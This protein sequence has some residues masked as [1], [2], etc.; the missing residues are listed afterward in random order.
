MA[1]K[2]DLI[3]EDDGDD[4]GDKG[5]QRGQQQQPRAPVDG[6]ANEERGLRPV[7]GAPRINRVGASKEDKQE[8]EIVEVDENDQ[9]LDGGQEGN[10]SQDQAG[11]RP[12][13][14]QQR[15]DQSQD[16]TGR[17]TRRETPS[18]RRARA[19]ARYNKTN[20]ENIALKRE[21]DDMRAKFDEFAGGTERRLNA[22]DAGRLQNEVASL[23]AEIARQD[24]II[25]KA[26][27]AQKAALDPSGTDPDAFVA[28]QESRDAAYVAKVRLETKRD[29]LKA[30]IEAGSRSGGRGDD[31]GDERDDRDQQRRQPEQRQDQRPAPLPPKVQRYA[32]EFQRNH[33]WYNPK[34]RDRDEVRDSRRVLLLD[35]EVKEDNFDPATQ[36][37][38]D[39]LESRMRDELPHRFED[40]DDAG[41]TRGNER[42]RGNGHANG[43]GRG[44][45]RM[46]GNGNGSGNG[47]GTQQTQQRR[48]PPMA[49]V[50]GR[51]GQRGKT[52]QV[53]ISPE[54]KK[55]MIDQGSL[56]PDGTVADAK[57][58][59]NT[60]RQYAIYDA[61]EGASR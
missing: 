49:D 14:D 38:W 29:G 21:L 12:L 10:L 44:E 22:A 51:G 5:Q 27:A 56:N 40:D 55:A 34:S 48:G 61:R 16:G 59:E 36:E 58:F 54:R 53:R 47:R 50:G 60:L 46:N 7:D 20:S 24:E 11:D 42:Q 25:R 1:G 17:Q 28:A 33:D 6:I 23:D 31:D 39:E 2:D 41:E 32:D 57:K 9:P 15:D 3:R 52:Q 43:N 35:Q 26:Q 4:D 37:Y 19:K 30:K 8:F 45:R 13:L 18:Q